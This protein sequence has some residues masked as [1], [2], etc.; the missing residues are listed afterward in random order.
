MVPAKINLTIYQGTDFY[1]SFQ[2]LTGSG[3]NQTPVNI[4][5]C[6]FRMHIR[7]KITDETPLLV[8]TTENNRIQIID[9]EQGKFKIVIDAETT[10]SMNFST[11]AV[12]DLEIIDSLN[13][14]SRLFGGTITLNPE[15]T[16]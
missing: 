6:M 3:D 1:K 8:L 14:V 10:A 12:Y 9:A 13:K 2:W 5:G 15:V 4:T 16:R 11:K 7:V